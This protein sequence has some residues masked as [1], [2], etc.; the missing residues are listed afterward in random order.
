M[1]GTGECRLVVALFVFGMSAD[2]TSGY[3]SDDVD[4][5]SGRAKWKRVRTQT[6]GIQV[7]GSMDEAVW[8]AVVFDRAIR[9]GRYRHST[10]RGGREESPIWSCVQGGRPPVRRH[11][12]E[13]EDALPCSASA[14]CRARER[15]PHPAPGLPVCSARSLQSVLKLT[16]AS[17][18]PR[19]CHRHLPAQPPRPARLSSV[20]L[21]PSFALLATFP[22][23]C[24][25][26]PFP[27]SVVSRPSLLHAT[28]VGAAQLYRFSLRTYL[29]WELGVLRFLFSHIAS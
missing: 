21:V 10:W 20:L 8:Y 26:Y 14:C 18:D 16:H 24:R 6:Q 25:L 7:G 11:L 29:R 13:V 3:C 17:P 22:P 4:L 23:T 27:S 9:R 12:P 15:A 2:E 1:A 5:Q 19:R 28:Y